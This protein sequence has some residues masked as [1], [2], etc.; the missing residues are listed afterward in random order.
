MRSWLE[1]P[2]EA[3]RGWRGRERNTQQDVGRRKVGVVAL[4]GSGGAEK[5]VMQAFVWGYIAEE[6]KCI[7]EEK[8]AKF[9]SAILLSLL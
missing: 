3:G 7:L 5:E 1:K 8:F 9:D 4:K 6:S 2:Q